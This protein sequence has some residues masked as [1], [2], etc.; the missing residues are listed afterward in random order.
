MGPERKKKKRKKKRAANGV[1]LAEGLP[2]LKSRKK[3][4]DGR[5]KLDKEKRSPNMSRRMSSSKGKTTLG[6][7]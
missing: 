3:C 1:L 7:K 5:R 6:G 4:E 2:C